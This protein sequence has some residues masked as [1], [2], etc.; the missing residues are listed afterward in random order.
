MPASG[1]AA[2]AAGLLGLDSPFAHTGLSR[3][4]GVAAISR[5]KF[6]LLYDFY[7]SI[8]DLAG[9]AVD[10]DMHPVMLF[11]FDNEIGQR[12]A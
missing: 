2:Q 11:P 5:V 8:E 9:V 7:L 12:P 3:T 10:G 1:S 6:S 4:K